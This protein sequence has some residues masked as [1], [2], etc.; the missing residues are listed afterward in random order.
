MQTTFSNFKGYPYCP[1]PS[2]SPPPYTH[3][4]HHSRHPG[5]IPSSVY[6]SPTPPIP[7]WF[8]I[9]LSPRSPSTYIPPQLYTSLLFFSYLTPFYIIFTSNLC[10]IHHP[11]LPHLACIH[12][13]AS[14]SPI[15]TSL[16]NFL[17]PYASRRI[18]TQNIVRP[19]SPAF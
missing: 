16:S 7:P 11:S 14:F 5:P 10:R 13:L 1:V 6:S 17:P 8:Q 15:P 4:S 3:F 9:P 19:F 12:L 2:S 18:P